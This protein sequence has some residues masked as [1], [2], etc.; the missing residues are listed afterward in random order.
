MALYKCTTVV[1]DA[2]RK[3]F[4]QAISPLHDPGAIIFS[5]NV[6]FTGQPQ[7]TFLKLLFFI[8]Y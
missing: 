5:F 6:I 2:E 7:L 1:G 3:N 4:F 8:F